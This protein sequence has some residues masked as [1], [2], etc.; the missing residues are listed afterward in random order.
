MRKPNPPN[1]PNPFVPVL[2]L[3]A[4]AALSLLVPGASAADSDRQIKASWPAGEFDVVRFDISVAELEVTAGSGDKIVIEVL[5]KC[6]HKRRDCEEAL[7]DLELLDRTRGKV[8]TIDLEGFP[9]WGKGRIEVEVF[10][11]IPADLD[12]DLD[13]GVGEVK[14]EGLRGNLDLDLGVGELTIDTEPDHLRSISLDV[15]V[16][17]AQIYGGARRVEGRRS[18]LI[19]SE[20]YWAEG[21]GGKRIKVDVGVGEVTVRLD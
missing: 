17:D 6:K 7:E 16:G 20:V 14:I 1:L 5:A 15:G 9:K 18:F 12:F 8:L 11:E 2:V 13:M 3:L 4:V 10:L 21:K 19:G